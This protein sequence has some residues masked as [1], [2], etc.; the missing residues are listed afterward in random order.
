MALRLSIVVKNGEFIVI[1]LSQL[2]LSINTHTLLSQSIFPFEVPQY[3]EHLEK[4]LCL[5]RVF[6]QMC[7]TYTQWRVSFYPRTCFI[8]K[9]SISVKF[10]VYYRNKNW[11][12]DFISFH[13]IKIALVYT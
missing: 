1:T 12:I 10:S 11:C 8:Y 7:E 5:L 2:F 4:M 9:K 3:S 6:S 13:Y